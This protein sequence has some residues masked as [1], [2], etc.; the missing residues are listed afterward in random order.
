MPPREDLKSEDSFF[1]SL[2]SGV[3]FMLH[4]LKDTKEEYDAVLEELHHLGI[5][6]NAGS[7]NENMK[8]LHQEIRGEWEQNIL[9]YKKLSTSELNLSEVVRVR[10]PTCALT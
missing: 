10:F 8:K 3:T 9:C 4:Q 1:F 2:V 5:S 6:P 7:I